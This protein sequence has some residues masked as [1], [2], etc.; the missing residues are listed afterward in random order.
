MY[1]SSPHLSVVLPGQKDVHFESS[2]GFLPEV[3]PQEQMYF[4]EL[5]VPP[6]VTVL[7][8]SPIIV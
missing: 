3:H 4:V 7:F 8:A 6:P 5:N 1:V 2:W